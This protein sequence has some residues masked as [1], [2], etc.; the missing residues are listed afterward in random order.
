ME[1]GKTKN[2]KNEIQEKPYMF[3]K[4]I[5]DEKMEKFRKEYLI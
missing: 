2:L 1:N 5:P 4:E 3:E